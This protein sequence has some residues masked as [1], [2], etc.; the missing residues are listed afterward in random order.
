MSGQSSTYAL[1]RRTLEGCQML[2]TQPQ[3]G[4]LASDPLDLGWQGA[5]PETKMG[6]GVTPCSPGLWEREG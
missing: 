5:A 4:I 6:S 1:D 2:S 3:V